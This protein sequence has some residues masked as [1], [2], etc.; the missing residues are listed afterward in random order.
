MNKNMLI[1]D[2]E[3]TIAHFRRFYTNS[4]S[5]SYSFPPRT[6]L[7]G[8]IAAVLGHERDSYYDIFSS[9]NCNIGLALRKPIRKIIQTVNYIRT[10]NEQEVTGSGGHTQVP[11]EFILPVE[12]ILQYRIYFLHNDSNIVEELYNAIITGNYYYPPYFG[13][14]ECPASLRCVDLTSEFEITSNSGA[15]E[16]CTIIPTDTIE[17]IDFK[18][19]YKLI[20]E[21]RVPVDFDSERRIAKVKSYI[22]EKNCQKIPQVRIKGELFTVSFT[23]GDSKVQEYGVFL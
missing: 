18:A 8:L 4:S 10:K 5:L 2:I 16:I 19:G 1:F 6:V 20:K 23:E 9:N 21:D 3:G 12:E 17:S 14:S 15:L 13:I 11:V 22:Y 7:I